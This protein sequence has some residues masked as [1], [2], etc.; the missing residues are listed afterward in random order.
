MRVIIAAGGTGG[1]IFPGV[2]I[3]REFKRRDPSTEILFVGTARGLESKIVP[4]EGFDLALIKVGALK[5]VKVFER[6]KSLAGLP[7]SFVAAFRI[8]KRFKPDVVIGVGGYSSGPTL[9]VAALSRIPT[10]VIEPNAMPG[11]TNR[12]LARFVDA[13][14]LS[15]AE[16]QKYFGHRGVVTGN[17]VRVDF[18]RLSKKARGEQ[19]NVLIFG[20]SQGAGAINRAMIAALPL[21]ASKKSRLTVTHQTGEPEFEMVR[22]AYADAGFDNADVKPFIHDMADRFARADVL[23]C[24]SGATTAAEVAAAGKAAIFIPFPF[25]TDDHQRKNA[26]AFERA[27]AGRMILQRDLTPAR[28]A[29]ELIGLIDQ[30]NEIDRMEEASRGLGRADSTDRAVDLAIKVASGP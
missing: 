29:E 28:L 4:R 8:L 16:A 14:A 20:G 11:F 9:L 23:I 13:A 25:A 10:M 27:G 7:M 26:E 22:R 5:G 12:V 3:A 15:F 6:I 18:A 1:H 2:A 21:V 19:L 24:R 17:P 30:P